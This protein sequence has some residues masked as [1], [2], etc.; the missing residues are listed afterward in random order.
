MIIVTD[1]REQA[2]LQ[3]S[4]PNI[5]R[6]LA[7]GDYSVQ[8]L[9]FEICIERKSLNDLIQSLFHDWVRFSKVLRRM[10][11]MNV[12]AIIC[13]APISHLMEKKYESETLPQSATG[14]INSILIDF[15]VP[16]LF[17][18]NREISSQWIEQLFRLYSEKQNGTKSS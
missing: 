7:T 8:G 6:T 10:A 15:G 14:R 16:T 17:L 9:E 2:P 3:F 18:D 12:A 4:C 5:T 13:E 11:S 1:T